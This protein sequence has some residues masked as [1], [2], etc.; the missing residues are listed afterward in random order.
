MMF[1]FPSTSTIDN[2][3]NGLLHRRP[4]TW[5]GAVLPVKQKEQY[6]NKQRDTGTNDTR[7]R[8]RE[9][10]VICFWQNPP[11]CERAQYHDTLLSTTDNARA[12]EFVSEMS[13]IALSI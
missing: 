9:A 11:H 4:P 12:V 1:A 3:K 10:R 8:D 5:G 7:A 13:E 6:C 2:Q